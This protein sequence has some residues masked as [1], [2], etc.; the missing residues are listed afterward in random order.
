MRIKLKSKIHTHIEDAD[1]KC[2]G[3]ITIP[4]E[5]LIKADIDPYEQVHVLDVSNGERA[6]TY[7]IPGDCIK[8]M[9]A[10]TKKMNIG[11]EINILAYEIDHYYTREW[12]P[13]IVE[14]ITGKNEERS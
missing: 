7:A 13:R 5:C 10:L 2:E 12:Y 11:D 3:S 6:I 4:E 9:G 1:I 14:W 8:I